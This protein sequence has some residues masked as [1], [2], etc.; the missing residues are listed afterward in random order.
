VLVLLIN[1][2][3]MNSLTDLLYRHVLINKLPV[4]QSLFQKLRGK[5]TGKYQITLCD[6]TYAYLDD[7]MM[8]NFIHPVNVYVDLDGEFKDLDTLTVGGVGSPPFFKSSINDMVTPSKRSLIKY[9]VKEI[10][11]EEIEKVKESIDRW[12]YLKKKMGPI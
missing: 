8:L 10:A 1:Y 11:K 7:Y 9:F 4:R 12:L 2:K 6:Y 3:I 5:I